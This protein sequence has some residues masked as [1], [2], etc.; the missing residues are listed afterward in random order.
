MRRRPEPQDLC[1]P[2]PHSGE[3]TTTLLVQ[4]TAAVAMGAADTRRSGPINPTQ[5][6]FSTM[7]M[8]GGLAR[9]VSAPSKVP[10]KGPETFEAAAITLCS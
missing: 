5:S 4:Q 2:T 1:V 7:S 6:S 8:I 10:K 9:L 3:A